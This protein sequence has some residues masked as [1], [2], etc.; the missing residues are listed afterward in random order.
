M[1]KYN[2]GTG[3]PDLPNGLKDAE[4][5]L[6][7]P[8]YM[9]LNNLSKGLAALNGQVTYD[10][11]EL[12]IQSQIIGLQPQNL[13]KVYAKATA[14]LPYGAIVNLHLDAGKIGA[15]LA[16]CSNDTKPAHGICNVSTGLA[17]GEYGEIIVSY[18][19]TGGITGTNVG[20]IYYLSTG[21]LVTNVRPTPAPKIVQAVGIG[22]GSLGFYLTVS[23]QF[24]YA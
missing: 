15:R 17:I 3:L 20:E 18:G 22:L 7:A 8:L 4:F 10:A 19:Y 11:S 1:P 2:L 6:V 21:G 12:S 24:A 9:A 5:K 16:D 13:F 14:V 23:P